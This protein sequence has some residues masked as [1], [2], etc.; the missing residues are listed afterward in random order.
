MEELENI[1]SN[2]E[3]GVLSSIIRIGNAVYKELLLQQE[4][5]FFHP[6][7]AG[8]KGRLRTKLVQMQA[9]IESHNP[10]FP[11]TFAHR[12]LPFGL[13]IPEL[14]TKN[15]VLHIAQSS[16]PDKLPSRSQYKVNLSYNKIVQ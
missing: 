11:F 14:H 10:N 3:L 7:L 6:Y 9:E 15:V 5:I 8:I 13:C 2:V 12:H 16:S 4:H 1:I